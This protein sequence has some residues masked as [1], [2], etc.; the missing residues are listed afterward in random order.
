MSYTETTN[1][2][3]ELSEIVEKYKDKLLDNII[4]LNGE[5]GA[6]KTTFV[7][8]FAEAV[9]SKYTVSSPTFTIM[10]KYETTANPIYHF[11]L[12][13]IESIDELEMTGFF[14]YIEY[15]GTIFIEWAEKFDIGSFLDNFITINI[16]Q[17]ENGKRKYFIEIF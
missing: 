9:C 10:Q 11:D 2:I 16:K 14:E 13:R 3:N 4:L 17:M 8:K 6:G 12:Y 5:L 7:K 1:D 15:P